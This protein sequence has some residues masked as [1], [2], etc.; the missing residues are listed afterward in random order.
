MH[1]TFPVLGPCQGY[2]SACENHG[3]NIEKPRASPG[4][5]DWIWTRSNGKS[6][7]DAGIEDCYGREKLE[8]KVWLGK[9]KDGNQEQNIWRPVGQK[10]CEETP[11]VI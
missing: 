11:D 10:L 6:G 4:E 7:D 5:K 8:V 1:T 9:N 2:S 3:S